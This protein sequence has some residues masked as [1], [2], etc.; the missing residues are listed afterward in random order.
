M[1]IICEFFCELNTEYLRVGLCRKHKGIRKCRC[2][3][4]YKKCEVENEKEKNK[5]Y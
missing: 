5:K 1:T 2:E 4:D 3:G